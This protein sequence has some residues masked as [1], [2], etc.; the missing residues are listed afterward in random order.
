MASRQCVFVDESPLTH[1]WEILFDKCYTIFDDCEFSLVL[2]V[3]NYSLMP[4]APPCAPFECDEPILVVLDKYYRIN[5]ILMGEIP[6]CRRQRRPEIKKKIISY[7]SIRRGIEP[8][9]L[10]SQ[11]GILTTN[12][13]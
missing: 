6:C 10:A 3:L 5:H 13:I 9:S 2:V 11:S 12:I 8:W 1:D 4:I 7:I